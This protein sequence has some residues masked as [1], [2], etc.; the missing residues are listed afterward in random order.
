VSFGWPA[1]SDRIAVFDPDEAW[2]DGMAVDV[3]HVVAAFTASATKE[4]GGNPVPELPAAI[5]VV[6]GSLCTVLRRRV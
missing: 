1:T 3:N 4:I 6:L 5:L 2:G